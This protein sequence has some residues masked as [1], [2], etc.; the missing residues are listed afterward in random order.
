MIASDL[1]TAN[2]PDWP[3]SPEDIDSDIRELVLALNRLPYVVTLSSCS[4]HD[5]E[6]VA[7]DMAVEASR[8]AQFVALL[9]RL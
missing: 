9:N 7:I 3:F 5:K 2:A 1:K 6:P 8:I 4:G